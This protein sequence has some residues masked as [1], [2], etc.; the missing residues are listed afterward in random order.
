M[1]Q[2]RQGD[3]LLIK[4]DSLPKNVT[5]KDNVLALG[6]KSGHYHEITGNVQTYTGGDTRD[7]IL[8][9][10]QWVVAEDESVLKHDKEGKPTGDHEYLSIEPGIY[11]VVKQRDEQV[12]DNKPSFRDWD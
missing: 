6:E 9:G 8:N 12:K 3:V 11:K 5:K 10:V 2:Y 4:V 7:D 1:N